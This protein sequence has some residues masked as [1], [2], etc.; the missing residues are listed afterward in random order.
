MVRLIL[1]CEEI[2]GGR[3]WPYAKV[4]KWSMPKAQQELPPVDDGDQPA[5]LEPA[6]LR[7]LP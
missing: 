4:A 5:E 7:L 3:T 6:E 1:T 2:D